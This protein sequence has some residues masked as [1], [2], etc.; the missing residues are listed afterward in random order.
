MSF[1]FCLFVF[2][3]ETTLRIG[4][5]S[6]VSNIHTILFFMKLT[7]SSAPWI[8]WQ[9]IHDF[10]FRASAVALLHFC[11]LLE[12]SEPPYSFLRGNSQLLEREKERGRGRGRGEGREGEE[13]GK[14][15]KEWMRMVMKKRE[16]FLLKGTLISSCFSFL[17]YSPTAGY[18]LDHFCVMHMP[19]Q[20]SLVHWAWVLKFRVLSIYTSFQPL[21][22]K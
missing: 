18:A 21:C 1:V 7:N 12:S 2:A 16:S 14:G 4:Y 19:A 8:Y 10:P 15:K 17:C 13:E 5:F 20:F 3:L 9:V 6:S 11:I 22:P